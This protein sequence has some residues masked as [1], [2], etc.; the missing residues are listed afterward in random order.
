MVLP[1]LRK[2]NCN[3]TLYR[4]LFLELVWGAKGGRSV[5]RREA[6][7]K[8]YA[9]KTVKTCISATIS[10]QSHMK[11]PP[12]LWYRSLVLAPARP[13]TRRTRSRTRG[14]RN[15][16]SRAMHIKRVGIQLRILRPA[17]TV[18]ELLATDC[19]CDCDCL[20]TRF[21]DDAIVIV[22]VIVTMIKIMILIDQSCHHP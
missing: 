2:N 1:H 21:P 19:D 5:V 11:I 16:S 12:L 7:H 14:S 20:K 18:S 15:Q 8:R 17:L 3:I 22:I 9:K 6:H 4:V 13:S 10:T